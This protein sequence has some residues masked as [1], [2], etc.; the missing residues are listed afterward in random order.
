M[1]FEQKAGRVTASNIRAACHTDPDKP[2]VS[3]LK[4]VC[5]PVAYKDTKKT[6]H[7][8][9]WGVEHEQEVVEK[10]TKLMESQ[11]TNLTVNKAGLV[12]TPKYPW[13]GASPDGVVT[14]DCHD[15]GV[16]EVKAPSSLQGTTMVEK[17]WWEVAESPLDPRCFKSFSSWR[18][19]LRAVARLI[20][21]ASSFKRGN[22][23]SDCQALSPENL[24][25]AK[26][27]VIRSLQ[28]KAFPKVFAC[29]QAGKEIPKQ[30]QLRKLSPYINKAG[31][32]RVG[33]RLSQAD[34]ES[35]ERNPLIISHQHHVTTLLIR[36]YHQKVQ[37]QGRHFTEGAVRLA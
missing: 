18:S 9:R 10:Y 5:Y 27:V 17:R 26:T 8:L 6:S 35:D 16:L 7:P 32:L 13:L 33:G 23:K 29:I 14:C 25:K 21:I 24:D 12:I 1:W 20:H 31:C 28:R 2:S 30:S 34:L 15:M 22:D 36:H 3:L 19:L 37:H 11:H 4:K